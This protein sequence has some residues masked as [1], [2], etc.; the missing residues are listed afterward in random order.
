MSGVSIYNVE[1]I[2]ICE[3]EDMAT[4]RYEVIEGFDIYNQLPEDWTEHFAPDKVVSRYLQAKGSRFDEHPFCQ[5]QMTV[6]EGG[7]LHTLY[8]V[9]LKPDMDFF[10]QYMAYGDEVRQLQGVW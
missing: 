7:M 3:D 2:K 5:A 1:Q 9:Y 10:I 8:Q 4:S 6:R